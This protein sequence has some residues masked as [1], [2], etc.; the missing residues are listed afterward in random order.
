MHLIKAQN[1]YMASIDI[2]I[3]KCIEEVDYFL[4]YGVPKNINCGYMKNVVRRIFLSTEQMFDRF[5]LR[6]SLKVVDFKNEQSRF[7]DTLCLRKNEKKK[8]K[9]LR[10]PPQNSYQLRIAKK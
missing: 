10:K 4:I 9:K 6:N 5:M 2:N 1:S 3:N 8:K 7:L